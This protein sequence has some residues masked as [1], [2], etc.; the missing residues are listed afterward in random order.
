MYKKVRKVSG[1][2]VNWNLKTFWD[3]VLYKPGRNINWPYTMTFTL[4]R[5]L[6]NVAVGCKEEDD[7]DRGLEALVKALNKQQGHSQDV[8]NKNY[9]MYN[10]DLE[11][12][13]FIAK[14][15][16]LCVYGKEWT[17]MV[18]EFPKPPSIP[19]LFANFR[20]EEDKNDVVMSESDDS[21]LC[22]SLVK[23]NPKPR[24]TKKKTNKAY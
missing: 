10:K 11:A 3:E 6:I 1:S 21:D 22:L 24:K 12:V 4:F 14:G 8:A 16:W 5:K 13:K 18:N 9:T 15:F 17:T 2:D 7:D 19:T 20:I 23:K